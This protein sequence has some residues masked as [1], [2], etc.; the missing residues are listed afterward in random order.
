[1]HQ[2]YRLSLYFFSFF[3]PGPPVLPRPGLKVEKKV[4]QLVQ[5]VTRP[6]VHGRSGP[7]G[8]VFNRALREIPKMKKDIFAMLREDS[9]PEP[10]AAGAL[11]VIN[12]W[13]ASTFY[14]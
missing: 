10:A 1:M 12:L 2:E 6:G 5:T 9:L 8:S 11:P 13:W 4:V 14:L 3:I 7:E